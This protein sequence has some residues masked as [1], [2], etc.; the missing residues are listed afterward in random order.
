MTAVMTAVV[1]A[2]RDGS[3]VMGLSVHCT[4]QIAARLVSDC[5]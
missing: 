2:R 4:G 5:S 3:C 1:T